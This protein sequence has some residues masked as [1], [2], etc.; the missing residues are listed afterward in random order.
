VIQ[1][2]LAALFDRRGQARTARLA[3]APREVPIY[4]DLPAAALTVI[5]DCLLEG[6][7]PAGAVPCRRG[8]PG[9]RCSAA[10]RPPT[11]TPRPL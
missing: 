7:A 3:H 10:P 2:R 4:R 5:W 6:Q 8:A 1:G 11:G 9:V